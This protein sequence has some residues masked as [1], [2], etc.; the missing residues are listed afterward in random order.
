MDM[1]NGIAI[2]FSLRCCHGLI[3][4]WIFVQFSFR[5]LLFQGNVRFVTWFVVV[6]VQLQYRPCFTSHSSLSHQMSPLTF[7]QTMSPMRTGSGLRLVVPASTWHGRIS[8][9]NI[10][11]TPGLTAALRGMRLQGLIKILW[12]MSLSSSPSALPTCVK[13]RRIFDI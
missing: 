8:V 4:C 11:G 5:P 7:G 12:M 9:I 1:T 2:D 13:T 10:Q 3:D 6:W